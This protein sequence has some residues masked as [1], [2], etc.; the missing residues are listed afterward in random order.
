MRN[1]EK[2]TAKDKCTECKSN[3]YLRNDLSGC[4]RDCSEDDSVAGKKYLNDVAATKTAF[5]ITTGICLVN[6]SYASPA[7]ADYIDATTV[8]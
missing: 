3:Y 7:I 1:C 5:G 6:C 4:V 8:K 2:C